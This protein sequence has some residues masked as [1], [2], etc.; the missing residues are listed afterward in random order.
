[1]EEELLTGV[2]KFYM[3]NKHY[4]FILS[5]DKEYFFHESDCV[6]VAGL[7]GGRKVDSNV[8]RYKGRVCATNVRLL[9]KEKR[10]GE[11]KQQEEQKG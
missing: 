8:T 7:T 1:M 5:G 6:V 2:I 10:D 9:K 4:G 3:P 11:R